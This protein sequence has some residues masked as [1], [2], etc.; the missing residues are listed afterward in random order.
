MNVILG[1]AEFAMRRIDDDRAKQ[2]LETIVTQVERITKIMNQFLTFARRRPA[3]RRLVA[4]KDVIDDSLEMLHERLAHHQVNVVTDCRAN[5]A[6]AG[7]SG[8]NQPG[9]AEP[10]YQ[11]SACHV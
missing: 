3:V 1:R 10:L 8:S 9:S 2:S 6:R 7:R 5:T 11:C 4:L